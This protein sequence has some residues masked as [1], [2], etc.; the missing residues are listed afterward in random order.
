MLSSKQWGSAAG[1]VVVAGCLLSG[2]AIAQVAP[3]ELND[4][5]VIASG[6]DVFAS[7]CVYCH[8][9]E[10]SG[11]R[12]GPLRSRSDL[13]PDY[14][15]NTIA[16]GRRAG[17]LNMPPWKNSLDETTRWQLTAYILSLGPPK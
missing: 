4:P 1:G 12:A 8:G 10:G 9:D 3:F 16:N 7:T 11:G 5:A 15:F 14:V 17:A 13:T 6:R 2:A